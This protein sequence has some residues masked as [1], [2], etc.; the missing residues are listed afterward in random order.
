MIVRVPVGPRASPAVL[1][2][3]HL[4]HRLEVLRDGERVGLEAIAREQR[5]RYEPRA[6][7]GDEGHRVLVVALPDAVREHELAGARATKV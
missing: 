1:V 6:D 2:D 3:D 5:D 7:I 4:V